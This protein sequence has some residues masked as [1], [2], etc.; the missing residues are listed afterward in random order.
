MLG[1][2]I[3]LTQIVV[4]YTD[5]YYDLL[6]GNYLHCE[7][8]VIQKADVNGADWFSVLLPVNAW[9]VNICRSREYEYC[10]D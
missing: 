1:M 3:T 7:G 4:R 9:H 8:L 6:S 2:C 10:R 5:P